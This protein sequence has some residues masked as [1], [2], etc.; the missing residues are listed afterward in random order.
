MSPKGDEDR[1][2]RGVKVRSGRRSSSIELLGEYTSVD[3]GSS[4]IGV[5]GK[6]SSLST[7][8]GG[9]DEGGEGELSVEGKLRKLRVEP[10]ASEEYELAL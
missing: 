10:D 2:F 8:P 3:G 1:T 7:E 5:T 4:E 6:S 9:E